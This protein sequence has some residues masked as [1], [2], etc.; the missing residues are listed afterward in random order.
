MKTKPWTLTTELRLLGKKKKRRGRLK[1]VG[2]PVDYGENNIVLL[3][4]SIIAYLITY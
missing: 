1:C 3:G 4:C 2:D